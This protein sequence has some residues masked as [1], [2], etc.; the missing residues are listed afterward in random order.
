[1]WKANK[2]A[3]KED[4]Q[5]HRLREK[6]VQ[7]SRKRLNDCTRLED[8]VAMLHD[9][10]LSIPESIWVLQQVSDFSVSQLKDLVTMHPVWE[11]VVQK[12]EAL[13]DELE[14]VASKPLSQPKNAP[15]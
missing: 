5:R 7:K 6:L 13:H 12:S 3:V 2:E 14:K 9:E 11:S 4:A 8:I 1:M 15:S 10:G